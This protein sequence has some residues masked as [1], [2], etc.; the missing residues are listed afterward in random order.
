VPDDWR[1]TPPPPRGPGLFYKPTV[2]YKPLSPNL[3]GY[4]TEYGDI[5]I[6]SLKPAWEQAQALLHERIHQILTPKLYFLRDV[7]VTMTMEG[8]N[9]SYLLRY[10]EE[11]LAQ[12]YALVKSRGP[13]SALEGIRFPVKSGYMTIGGAA[14]AGWGSMSKEALGICL[15]PINVGGTFN[16]LVHFTTQR[17]SGVSGSW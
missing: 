2:T 4:T 1:W 13:G 3:G 5:V 11:A 7:R 9:R 10:L 17:S 15:G 16:Y 12:T 6:N 14:T 8:Y